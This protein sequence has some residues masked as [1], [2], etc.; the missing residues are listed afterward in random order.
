[1]NTIIQPHAESDFNT[2]LASLDSQGWAVVPL[3]APAEVA[4]TTAAF[5]RLAAEADDTGRHPEHGPIV[6]YEPGFAAAGLAPAARE[7]GV[8]KWFNYHH[9]PFFRAQ[10]RHPGIRGILERTLGPGAQFLQSLA[11]SKPPGIGGPKDWHQDTPYFPLNRVDRCLGFWIALDHADLENG[12]MQFAPGSHRRGMIR[13][14]QGPTG[15]RLPP[16]EASG[17]QRVAVQVPVQSGTCIVFHANCM[18]FTD[19]NRSQKRRRAAQYHYVSS[20]CRMLAQGNQ[21][22][23]LEA[24]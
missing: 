15:W 24:L 6:Q 11:L 18:H 17:C 4:A 9:D 14:E 23:V 2:L 7:L 16:E 10:V 20:D 8:R 21:A 13:H 1:M 19:A 12:C 5:S 3:L 22:S